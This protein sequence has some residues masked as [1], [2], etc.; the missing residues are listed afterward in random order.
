MSARF[1]TP[2]DA[3]MDK[4]GTETV[5]QGPKVGV[6]GRRV[7]ISLPSTYSCGLSAANSARR[8][9]SNTNSWCYTHRHQLLKEKL[10]SIW[11]VHSHNIGIN[12]FLTIIIVAP[13]Y[14]LA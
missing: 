10:T 14:V 13:I 12:L 7:A 1:V 9:T 11:N 6:F 5:G 8:T 4:A 3:I 2:P